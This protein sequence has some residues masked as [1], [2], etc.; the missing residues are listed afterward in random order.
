MAE[1]VDATGA[2]VEAAVTA[3]LRLLGV[4]RDAVEVEVLDEGARGVFGLGAREARVRLTARTGPGVVE[5][6]EPEESAA[7]SV[8]KSPTAHQAGALNEA[9]VAAEVVS[10][11]LELMGFDDARVNSRRAE[12]SEG[13]QIGP[14]EIDIHGTDTDV[15][16]G[17]RGDTLA[18]LQHII[19][20]MV[21][22]EVAGR[23]RLVVDVQGFKA[24]RESTLT[25]MALRLADQA[26]RTDRTVVLEPM[27]PFERRIV[28]I[29]LRDH[30][31]VTTESIGEGDRRKV[32]IIPHL[33]M[34]SAD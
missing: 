29:A 5:P 34:P 32:T 15:L 8:D 9:S 20:L 27:Q 11:L 17:R 24:R 25:R 21:G 31:Q 28:H 6:E 2:D 18:A 1:S 3:G 23:T 10:D 26:V 13:Q 12:P 19:R 30:P 4:D 22:R 33:E 14:V 7:P 16:I